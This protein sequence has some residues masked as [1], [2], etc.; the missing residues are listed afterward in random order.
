VK[1]C[2]AVYQVNEEIHPCRR[3]NRHLGAHEALFVTTAE[4]HVGR[5]LWRSEVVLRW[6]PWMPIEEEKSQ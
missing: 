6:S 3:R 1:P 5:P 2:P 4:S